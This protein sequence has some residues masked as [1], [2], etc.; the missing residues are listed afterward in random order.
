[1]LDKIKQLIA[2]ISGFSAHTLEEA[3]QFRIKHLSK[4][5]TIALLFEDFKNVPAEQKKDI[6]KALNEL[7]TAAQTK[8]NELKEQL[9]NTDTGASGMDLTLPGDPLQMGSRHPLSIVR[10]EILSIFDKLGFTVS[11]G[12]EIEDDWHNFSALNFPEEHPARDMQDTFFIEKHPDIVL[13]THTSSVQVRDMET[14]ELPIRLVT[15]GRVFRNEAI[16]ARAHCI[17]HQI[18]ALYLSLIHI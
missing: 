4:K 12:P 16:S 1:M 7:K 9:C 5:G 2:E 18:E 10:N 8:V 11:E 3:E 17:F 6:G 15:P 14:H 13:H